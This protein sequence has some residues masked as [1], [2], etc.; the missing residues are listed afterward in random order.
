MINKIIVGLIVLSGI[1][2]FQQ[3]EG[4][5]FYP[6]QFAFFIFSV[7]FLGS[8][9]ICQKNKWLGLLAGWCS[10][11]FLITYLFQRA[12]HLYI[13]KDT[14]MGVGIFG[15]YYIAKELKL[16][17]HYLKFLI[18]A[19]LNAILIII[20]ALDHYGLPFIKVQGITGFL[21]NASVSACFI[22]LTTPIFCKYFKWGLP[23][24]FLSV[25]L[26]NSF[27]AMGTFLIALLAY[28]WFSKYRHRIT[29][30]ILCGIMV[31]LGCYQY[32]HKISSDIAQRSAMYLG[33]L[34]GIRRNPILGWG[35][36]SFEQVMSQIK[37]GDSQYGWGQFNYA[38]AI[39]NHPHNEIL[40][41]WW[42][43]GIMFPILFIIGIW[44]TFKR[45]TRKKILPFSI[46]ICG[47]FC[48][49]FYFLNS[50]HWLIVMLSLGIYDNEE[51]IENA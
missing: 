25:I 27:I 36:G 43:C 17:E 42:S 32:G 51:V 33:T 47:L 19:L 7:L 5:K 34:D 14:L 39:M 45:F 12:L 3:I 41:G 50:P 49:M 31:T 4:G 18:P 9:L 6:S 35:I 48:M 24:I 46:I 37:P 44:G 20:Q 15:I 26:S 10:V 22:A 1:F 11:S 13:F 40:L 16:T 8:Y 28:S 38:D 30:I 2:S 29:L 23:L 21:G